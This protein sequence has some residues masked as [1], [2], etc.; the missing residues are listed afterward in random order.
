MMGLSSSPPPTL[1]PGPSFLLN[2]LWFS[3]YQALCSH[4]LARLTEER[5][6]PTALTVAHTGLSAGLH[7]VVDRYTPRDHG[8]GSSGSAATAGAS[9]N[10]TPLHQGWMTDHGLETARTGSAGHH[11]ASSRC[12]EPAPCLVAAGSWPSGGNQAISPT[13]NDTVGSFLLASAFPWPTA[14]TPK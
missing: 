12:W 11:L 14:L 13:T 6:D 3:G 9:N 5:S 10:T 1:S 7:A 4:S 2:S 8:A